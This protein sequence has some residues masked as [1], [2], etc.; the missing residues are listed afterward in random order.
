MSPLFVV[1]FCALLSVLCVPRD[2]K[3]KRKK[4]QGVWRLL[5]ALHLNDLVEALNRDPAAVTD[6]HK[7]SNKWEKWVGQLGKIASMGASKLKNYMRYAYQFNV[8]L[9]F[10]TQNKINDIPASRSLVQTGV[11]TVTADVSANERAVIYCAA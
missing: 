11:V 9:L 6:G 3:E 2:R 4:W 10:G 5:L 8:R 1:G 7:Y